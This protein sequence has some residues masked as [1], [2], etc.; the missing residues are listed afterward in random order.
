M[1]PAIEGNA[2]LSIMASYELGKNDVL[3]LQN[4]GSTNCPALYRFVTIN[5]AGQG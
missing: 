5:T 1:T 4:S 2:S 3:L